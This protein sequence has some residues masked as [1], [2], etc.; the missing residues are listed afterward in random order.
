MTKPFLPIFKNDAGWLELTLV[1]LFLAWFALD[2][3]LH[4]SDLTPFTAAPTAPKGIALYVDLL[5]LS[6]PGNL[7]MLKALMYVA[8]AFFALGVGTGPAIAAI[9]AGVT[10]CQTHLNSYG[11]IHH[12]TQAMGIAL[13][14]MAVGYLVHFAGDLARGTWRWTVFSR[15]GPHRLA[16]NFGLQALVGCLR[17]RGRLQARH[18]RVRV[19]H[20]PALHRRGCAQDRAPAPLRRGRSGDARAR[21]EDRQD[22]QRP[23]DPHHY[24]RGFRAILRALRL[25]RIDQPL[26]VARFR[27]RPL[28]DA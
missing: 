24:R 18:Q 23:P 8:L 11:N 12:G 19:V 25:P 7:K 14:F 17:R 27:A 21:R 15:I 22:H 3:F 13:A 20:G 16:F 1:R 10:L 26:V 4:F 9:A 6:D 2:Y 28:R 5:P